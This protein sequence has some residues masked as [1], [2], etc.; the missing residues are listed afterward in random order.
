MIKEEPPAAGIKAVPETEWQ[1]KLPIRKWFD[2][3][4]LQN[5]IQ[6]QIQPLLF[7]LLSA[8]TF[9]IYQQMKLNIISS[10]TQRAEGVAMQVIDSANMMMVDGA[11]RNSGDRQLMIKKIAE[12]QRLD[13]LRLLR[14]DQV[15]RQFGPGLPEEHLDDP[16]VKQTIE[17][18]VR[19]GKSIPYVSIEQVNGKPMLRVITPYLA[20]HDFHGTDCLSCHHVRAG[21]A[22]GAS[23]LR[24]DLSANFEILHTVLKELV[25][26]QIILQILLFFIIGRIAALKNQQQQLEL[27]QRQLT[28]LIEA[29]PDAIFLKDGEGRWLII[30]DSA[31][32]MFQLHDLPWQ[33]K[34]EMELADLQP[35]FRA[36][37][38][39][40]L[41]GDEKAWQAGHLLVGEESFTVE[42]QHVVVETRKVPLFG[43]EGQRKELLVIGRDITER[44]RAEAELRALKDDLEIRVA[45]RTVQLE[46]AN[47]ELEA[48]SYSVSHDLRTP[49]RAIDGFSRILLD[50]Y[51]DKLDD[52]G[53][54]LL[55]VV[56]DN[57]GRMGQ[58]IDDILKFSRAGRVEINFSEV[59]MERL[60]HEV[61]EE[62]RPA[63]DGHEVRVEIE[64]LPSSMGDRAMMH[65]VFVN[66]LSNALKFSRSKEPARIRVGA[67]IG[68]G[69]IAYH[70]K[71]N[72]AGF[73]MQYVDKLFGVF[74]RLHGVNEFEGTGIGL[75]IVK[76]IV[77]R[78]GGRVWAEGKVNE[79]AT[80]YFTLPTNGESG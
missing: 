54:R 39:G 52:E 29:I 30:N 10:G 19:A 25:C 33:G 28:A 73:D 21:S 44:K 43:D 3:R 70:V 76:R 49:L 77:N 69:E 6:L 45:E 64:H 13:S 14:T 20:S 27:A 15:V 50:D 5:K 1:G 40:C 79:G 67:S 23:D 22:N 80:I 32:Q 12:G 46:A 16:L 55:N 71:D 47:K 34:T 60:A 58:L 68:Q 78:H 53:R 18:S 17:D 74:Q 11:I 75:A 48:F 41:V 63:M 35:A 37:H 4:S 65:Q 26:G 9:F 61:F 42:D 62:L 8:A 57:T 38:E 31:K 2:N 51:T 24:I 72:G 36:A 59:D 56:R 7:L 66:L